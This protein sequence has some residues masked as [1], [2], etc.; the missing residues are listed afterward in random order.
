MDKDDLNDLGLLKVDVLA[1]GHA[2]RAA[3]LLRAGHR[4][5][6]HRLVARPPAP[7]G[8][9]GLRHDVPR[10]HRGVFQIE[11]RAQMSM[12][13][14]LKPASSYDLVIEVALVRPGPIQGDMVHPYLRRREARSPSSI[15]ARRAGG[16]GAHHGRADLP[17]AGHA[18]GHDAAGFTAGEADNLRR[19]MGSWE[20]KGDLHRFKDRLAAGLVRNSYP[21][22]FAERICRQIEGF[23]EYGFPESHAASFALLVYDSAWLKHYE[24]AAFTC[25]LLNSSPWVFILRRS[26]T[27][28]LRQHGGVILPADVIVSDYECTL[29]A[30]NRSARPASSRV[31]PSS[32]DWRRRPRNGWSWHAGSAPSRA[33]TIWRAAP[34]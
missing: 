22:E 4:L 28:V 19:A 2:Q 15:P 26:F 20:R 34:A 18:A 14:R 25:A 29:E 24:P 12:L 23:G 5:A 11:S 6:R 17:G 27:L 31:V 13:P 32:K 30:V 8:P 9:A 16:P 7:G 21:A 33:W 3:S 10:R 1:P